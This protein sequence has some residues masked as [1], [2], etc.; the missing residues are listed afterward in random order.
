MKLFNSYNHTF[1]SGTEILN[2]VWDVIASKDSLNGIWLS[3]LGYLEK[4]LIGATGYK[5]NT[6]VNLLQ[7]GNYLYSQAGTEPTLN[8]AD[9]Q[10]NNQPSIGFSNSNFQQLSLKFP[11][12]AKTVIIVYLNRVMG[13]YLIYAPR[14]TNSSDENTRLY[15]DAFPPGN[16]NTLWAQ[17]SLDENRTYNATSRINGRVV[18]SSTITPLNTARILSITNFGGNGQVQSISGFGGQQGIIGGRNPRSLQNS[19]K[20][21]IAAILTFSELLSNT[22]LSTIEAELGRVYINYTGAVLTS[23]PKLKRTVNTFFSF[24]FSTIVLDEWFDISSYQLISPTDLGLTFTGSVLSGNV[25]TVYKGKLKFKVINSNLLE[26][27][28]ELD[29]EICRNDTIVDTFPKSNKIVLALS[30]LQNLTDASYSGLYVEQGK[31]IG[32]EDCRRVS[33]GSTTDNS[34]PNL[35]ASSGLEPSLTLNSVRFDELSELLSPTGLGAVSFLWVYIQESYG[36]RPMLDSFPDSKGTGELWTISSVNQVHGQTDIT[37]LNTSIQNT[38]INTLNYKNRLDSLVFITASQPDNAIITFSG[39]RG[40]RGKL[41]FFCSWSEQL[42][43]AEFKEVIATLCPR[44]LNTLAPVIV[45]QDIEYRSQSPV[46]VDLKTK[47]VDLQGLTL[48]YTITQNNYLAT[49]TDGILSFTTTKDESLTFVIQVTNTLSLTTTLTFDV[50]ITLKTNPL[51]IA[52]R[53]LLGTD[54]IELFLISELDSLTISSQLLAQWNDYRENTIFLTGSNVRLENLYQL[55]NKLTANFDLDGSSYLSL[56]SPIS[57][58]C[59]ILSYV[60]KEFGNGQAFLL[61]QT[62]DAGFASGSDNELFNLGQTSTSILNSDTYINTKKRA[63]NYLLINAVLNTVVINSNSVL[64]IDS[65]AKDRVFS[66]NSIKG[67]VP[68][69][70]VLNRNVTQTEASQINKLIRDYYDSAKFV[71]LLH[72]DNLTDSSTRNKSLQTTGNIDTDTKKFGIASYQLVVNSS[73]SPIL[74]ENDTDFAFLTEEFT[75]SFWF[76]L[77]RVLTDKLIIY[78]QPDLLVYI[79][80]TNL[81]VGRNSFSNLALLSYSIPTNFYGEFRHIQI[82]R[83]QGMLYLFVQGIVIANITDDWEYVDYNSPILIGQV[84]SLTTV[85]VNCWIDELIVY[86]RQG[87]NDAN[88]TVPAVAYSL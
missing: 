60:K 83:Y 21:K 47:V 26:K 76:Y 50:D 65:I 3:D 15:Y 77:D 28:F 79:E 84:N 42:N 32:W 11:I 4:S 61:G 33:N 35:L 73:C 86:R 52:L 36:T 46:N 63:N 82:N 39:F 45:N 72:C 58:K 69:V 5:V 8:L 29:L 38:S 2:S 78:S 6:W 16:S 75:I 44:F 14:Q 49:I 25:S 68:T 62:D 37:K 55:D 10:F 19:V 18:S 30:T 9:S 88:F 66:D 12:L 59:F 40:L 56:N 53:Q 81:Y 67:Y 51:Y 85:G 57:G 41:L 43:V 70:T 13:S 22:E 1:S 54:S 20:G 7:D 64:S 34:V 23:T 24:D 87:F 74:L 71:L 80:G 48:S 27:V 31:V 17:E